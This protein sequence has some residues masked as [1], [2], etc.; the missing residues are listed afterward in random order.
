MINFQGGQRSTNPTPSHLFCVGQTA[1]LKQH[2]GTKAESFEL[3]IIKTMMPSDGGSLQY[4]VHA[5]GENHDRVV[6]EE[7]LKARG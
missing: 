1:W 2:A 7:S 4:R 5:E 6:N 3:C